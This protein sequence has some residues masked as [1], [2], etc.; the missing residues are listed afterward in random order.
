MTVQVS[1]LSPMPSTAFVGRLDIGMNWGQLT[2]GFACPVSGWKGAHGSMWKNP[3]LSMTAGGMGRRLL[4]EPSW[5]E[6][7]H[8]IS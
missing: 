2:P 6:W 1:S 5:V 7:R 8:K 4:F 3:S